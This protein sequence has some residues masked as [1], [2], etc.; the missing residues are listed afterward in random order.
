MQDTPTRARKERTRPRGAPLS[1]IH[2]EALW[3]P[4]PPVGYDDEGYPCESR[5]VAESSAH[6]DVLNYLQEQCRRLARRPGRRHG[7]RASADPLRTRQPPSR[8]RTGHHR[9]AP[10]WPA[11]EELLQDVGRRTTAR[12]DGRRVVGENLAPGRGRQA[13][14]L[15][16]SGRAASSGRS[17]LSGGCRTPSPGTASAMASTGGSCQAPPA[18]SGARCCARSFPTTARTCALSIC[19]PASRSHRS[20]KL[21][22]CARR[23]SGARS[24]AAGARR[25]A[26]GAR[27]G[28][29]GTRGRACGARGPDCRIGG[30]AQAV[31]S[32][33]CS[34]TDRRIGC[35]TN[36]CCAEPNRDAACRSR[37]SQQSPSRPPSRPQRAL[38]AREATAAWPGSARTSALRSQHRPSQAPR[39]NPPP[40]GPARPLVDLRRAPTAHGVRPGRPPHRGVDLVDSAAPGTSPESSRPRRRGAVPRAD[41]G[42]QRMSPTP[43]D[44]PWTG[45]LGGG[46]IVRPSAPPRHGPAWKRAM[47]RIGVLLERLPLNWAMFRSPCETARPRTPRQRVDPATVR[48]RRL[49][50]SGNFTLG[51]TE[52]RTL[53]GDIGAASMASG[54]R[55]WHGA[56]GLSTPCPWCRSLRSKGAVG[57]GWTTHVG[58]GPCNARPAEAKRHGPG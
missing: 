25:S 5:N 35:T 49:H 47:S 26:A 10:R 11:P 57:K 4:L 21:C 18:V 48:H 55:A 43:L 6:D 31:A 54:V 28:E 45:S 14:T 16:R 19:V 17:T 40:A 37:R 2:A 36:P 12:P 39:G 3:R 41:A 56:P 9:R 8:H 27:P 46:P 20:G 13:R 34:R 33:W 30:T 22:R 53:R 51:Q 15:R 23:R 29:S 52:N 7:P 24:S 1:V 50:T 32:A 44:R 38:A 58:L 42:P